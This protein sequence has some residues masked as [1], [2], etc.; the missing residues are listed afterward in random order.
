MI[1]VVSSTIT[2]FLSLVVVIQRPTML[3]VRVIFA[4]SYTAVLPLLGV[5]WPPSS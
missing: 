1:G 2:V 5:S 3:F 4:S